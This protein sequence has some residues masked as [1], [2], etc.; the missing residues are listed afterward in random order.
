MN[1]EKVDSIIINMIKWSIVHLAVASLLLI[2]TINLINF[3]DNR[4]NH[5]YAPLNGF[6]RDS[7]DGFIA[8]IIF[9]VIFGFC[10]GTIQGMIIDIICRTNALNNL[11][12][13]L[14]QT[15][16][17]VNVLVLLFA[18]FLVSVGPW[19]VYIYATLIEIVVSRK[20]LQWWIQDTVMPNV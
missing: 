8:A 20:F 5:H 18:L 4:I 19:Y 3:I 2:E 17:L 12:F 6:F 14:K 7:V 10:C 16:V 13:R 9:G 1:K 15:I 11:T